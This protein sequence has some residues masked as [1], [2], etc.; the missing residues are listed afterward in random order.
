MIKWFCVVILAIPRI[1]Y[2][3]IKLLIMNANPK[4]YSFERRYRVVR[5]T[6]LWISK[7]LRVDLNIINK[8]IITKPHKNGRIYVSN[9]FN[10]FEAVIFICLSKKPLVFISKKE[11]SKVPF[12]NTHMKAIKTICIDRES[13]RQSL[14]CCKEAGLL[15][16]KGVDI[17]LFAEGTR[18]K[19][20]NVAPFKAALPSIVHYSEA[21]TVLLTMYQANYP[22]KWR[23]ITYPKEKVYIKVFEPLPYSYYLENRKEFN[24]LTHDMVAGQ[25][26]K[27]KSEVNK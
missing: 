25:L 5:Q 22:L 7:V 16:K 17:V 6:C 9:H 8:D 19:D 10:I 4:K 24:V 1:L 15:A 11:N 23:W 3:Q 14:K 26:E 18:S 13:A 21:E 20:G 12:L 2:S 27:F